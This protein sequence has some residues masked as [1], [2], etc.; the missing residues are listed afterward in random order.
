MNTKPDEAREPRILAGPRSRTLVAKLLGLSHPDLPFRVSDVAW[1]DDHL[2]VALTYPNQPRTVLHVRDTCEGSQTPWFVE[3]RHLAMRY[4]GTPPPKAAERLLRRTAPAWGALSLSRVLEV[5]RA[6]PERE[7]LEAPSLIEAPKPSEAASRTKRREKL[8]IGTWTLAQ[9]YA[10]FLAVDVIELMPYESIEAS[11]PLIRISHSDLECHCFMPRE[12][13]SNMNLV[14]FPWLRRTERQGEAWKHLQQETTLST[15]LT[16]R[17]I[18]LGCDSQLQEVLSQATKLQPPRPIVFTNTCL[19]ATIGEDVVSVVKRARRASPVPILMHDRSA[20]DFDHDLFREL[21]VDRRLDAQ[22][23]LREVEPRTVNLIGFDRDEDLE[24]IEKLL[25][26]LG[27]RVNVALLPVVCADDVDAFPRAALNVFHRCSTHW[28]RFFEQLELDNPTPS[29]HLEGPYGRTRT[30]AWLR[31]VAEG[32]GLEAEAASKVVDS[33]P[34][35]GMLARLA[36]RAHEHVIG[37]VVPERD[38]CCLE[39]AGYTGGVPLVGVIEDLGF[40]LHFLVDA[41]PEGRRSAFDRLRALLR[42]PDVHELTAF[43]GLEATRRVLA[44][45]PAGAVVSNYAF[46]WRL[47]EAGKG[48]V[49]LLHFDKGLAGAVRTTRRLLAACRSSFLKTHRA[50]LGRTGLGLRPGR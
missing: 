37:I 19:P 28:A 33:T 21:L 26:A 18:I 43:D 40:R 10:D 31:A 25:E 23:R 6:D 38:L 32:L 1:V 45:S 49:S 30:T 48:R 3:G 15:D 41:P 46:D 16:E 2:E 20:A 39:D 44:E 17:T 29:L 13:S 22:Q 24:E 35:Y 9:S 5:L 4:R 42:D 34:E 27:V 11:N 14:D 8:A 7:R 12:K 36:E 50:Y 47:S